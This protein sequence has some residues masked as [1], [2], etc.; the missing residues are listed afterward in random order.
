MKLDNKGFTVIELVLSF[1]FVM[2]LAVGMFG[3]VNNY[4]NREEQESIRS[5]LLVLNNTLTADIYKDIN[6]RLVKNMSYCVDEHNVVIDKCIVINFMDNTTK[7]LEITSVE[8]TIEDEGHYFTYDN[9]FILYGG[10]K[11]ENPDPVFTRLINDYML[12]YTT[13]RDNLEYGVI[14]KINLR[15]SHQDLNDELVI[16]IVATGTN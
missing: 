16:D 1:V 10:I 3:L 8:E 7:R 5:D 4:R 12:T 15:I 13:N 14:Y 2:F 11:Y 9:Q 6:D